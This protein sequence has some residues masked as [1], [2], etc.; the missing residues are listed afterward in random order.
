M[1]L[2]EFQEIMESSLILI[3]SCT[4]PSKLD[5]PS[6][7]LKMDDEFKSFIAKADSLLQ[8]YENQK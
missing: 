7:Y 8:K 2:L 4:Y 6:F 3:L 1:G 5:N